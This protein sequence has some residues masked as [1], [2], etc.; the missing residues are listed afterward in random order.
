MTWHAG[1]SAM[2][3]TRLA[4]RGDSTVGTLEN[5]QPWRDALAREPRR[6]TA[7]HGCEPSSRTSTGRDGW[8]RR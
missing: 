8:P 6:G 1:R 4:G 5:Q 3:L 7:H 2:H